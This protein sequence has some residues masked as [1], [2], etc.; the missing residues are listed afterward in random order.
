[1]NLKD[2]NKDDEERAFLLPKSTMIRRKTDFLLILAMQLLYLSSKC[3][4]STIGPIYTLEARLKGTTTIIN[5]LVFATYPFVIVNTSPIVEKY[6][7]K[8]GQVKTLFIGSFLEGF[9]GILFGFILLLPDHLMFVLFSFLLRAVTAVGGAF[10]RTAFISILSSHYPDHNSIIIDV[11]E[12]ASCIGLMLGPLV[13]GVLYSIAG[14][15]LP[16]IVTGA[17]VW[18]ILGIVLLAIPLDDFHVVIKKERAISITKLVKVP[19]L[20]IMGMCIVTAGACISFYE[21]TIAIQLDHI[22]EGKV[23]R[24]QI[25]AYFII[26]TVFYTVS[27]PLWGYIVE[28]KIPGK[29]TVMIGHIL[30]IVTFI[31]MGPVPFL[32]EVITATPLSTAISLCL[33][34]ISLGP[35]LTHVTGTMKKYAIELGFDNNLLQSGI[36]TRLFSSYFFVG[37]IIGPIVGG[38]LIQYLTFSWTCLILMSTLCIEGIILVIYVSYDTYQAHNAS[39]GNPITNERLIS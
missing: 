32:Q 33:L 28:H 31:L 18:L 24:A 34:G 13:G 7:P 15:E 16:F 6:L 29:C 2:P 35:Y 39:Q 25:G 1:M 5:G 19:E 3:V 21:S 20:A 12:L 23:S 17:S 37:S 10:S 8:L 36:V 9:G 26:P 4:Y 22:T 30:L 38:L 14:F 27:A 11:L